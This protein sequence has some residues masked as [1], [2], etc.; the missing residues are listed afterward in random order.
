M[1][2]EKKLKNKRFK[3]EFLNR[4]VFLLPNLFTTSAMVFGFLS[5]HFSITNRFD[6][7]AAFIFMAAILDALDGRVARMTGTQSD[8]GAQFDSLSDMVSFG[9]SPA[10]L[11]YAW[12]LSEL[13]NFGVMAAFVFSLAVAIRLARFNVTSS[14]SNSFDFQ[15]LPSPAAA[16]CAKF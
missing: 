1:V 4:G 11:V 12:N 2:K 3:R 7:A 16:S 6:L 9:V 8:F 10:V 13:G 15:G 14:L 5:I